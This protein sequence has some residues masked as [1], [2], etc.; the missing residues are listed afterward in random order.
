VQEMVY[1]KA[2]QK[3]IPMDVSL[4]GSMEEKTH[5][6]NFTGCSTPLARPLD[7]PMNLGFF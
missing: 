4:S 2:V 6:K 7:P 5:P 1:L 3:V